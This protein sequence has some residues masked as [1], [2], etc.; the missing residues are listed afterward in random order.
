MNNMKRNPNIEALRVLMMLFIIMLHLSGTYYNIDDCRNTGHQFEISS[1][2]SLR[3][4]LLLGVNTFA[5]I[6]GYFGIRSSPISV[7]GVSW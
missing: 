5:F 1:I 4:I 6:S 3:M 7:G 2:L